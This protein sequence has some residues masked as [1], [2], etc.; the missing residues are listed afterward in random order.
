M[1]VIDVFMF[2]AILLLGTSSAVVNATEQV[3]VSNEFDVKR[4]VSAA[5]DRTMQD[6]T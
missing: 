1:R 2:I 4:F 6:V 5:L 3:A